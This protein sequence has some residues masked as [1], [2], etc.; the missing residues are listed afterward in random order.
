MLFPEC[1]VYRFR[2]L[3]EL[4]AGK[5]SLPPYLGSTFRGVFAASFRRLVCVTGA[6]VCEGCLL[7]NRCSYPYLFETPV[8]S[9]VPEALQKRFRDAPRPYV[10]EA[11]FDYAGEPEVELGLVLVGRAVDFLPYVIYVVDAMGK[12]GIGKARVRYRLKTVR[13]GS[14]AHGAVIFRA[15][16]KILRDGFHAITL[17]GL[18]KAEDETV[19]QATL[20]FLTPLRVKKFGGYH[21]VDEERIDFPVLMDLLLGRVEALSF[22]HCGGQWAPTDRLREEAQK[23]QVTGR[24][25]SFRSLERYS[26][27]QQRTL[28]LHGFVGTIAFAGPLAEFLPLLRLGEYLHI[29]AGTAFG[30]GRYRLSGAATP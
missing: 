30:L 18:R 21:N 26:N 11:P 10:L 19:R 7:L 25:L 20:E 5:E 3:L 8:P 27:R 15:E 16:E 12:S 6:P 24:H 28:P 1:T 17:A 14:Q 13:D 22:L 4:G 23:I 9:A 29:G 2:M